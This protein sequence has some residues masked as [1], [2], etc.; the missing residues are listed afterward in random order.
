M[1]T[2]IAWRVMAVIF[3]D[4]ST[5]LALCGVRRMVKNSG[6]SERKAEVVR[7]SLVG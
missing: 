1:E 3:D 7:R 4:G 2:Q 6:L 5:F